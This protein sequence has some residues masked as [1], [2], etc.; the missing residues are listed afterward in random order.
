[1]FYVYFLRS[2]DNLNQFY[3]GY[4]E[5]IQERLN[6]HNTGQVQSTKPYHPWTLIY[7]EV[8]TSIVDAKQREQYLKTTK[9]RRTL[10]LMLQNTLK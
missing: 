9:G 1:M 8:F 2:K 7:Y 4:T 10:R 5:D 3:V 6:K